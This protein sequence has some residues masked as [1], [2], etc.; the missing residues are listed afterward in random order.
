MKDKKV[1]LQDIARA[2]GVSGAT[3]SRVVNRTGRVSPEIAAR[4]ARIA[5]RMKVDLGARSRPRLIA[6]ILG[7]RPLLHP[8][9]SRILAGVEA[10]CASRDYHVVFVALRYAHDVPAEQLDLPRLLL[11]QDILDGFVLAGMHSGNLIDRL[12]RSGAPLAVHG[13]NVLPPWDETQHDAVWYDDV[14]GAHAMTRHMLALGHTD[15]WFVGN[16]RFPWFD[17]CHEGYAHAMAE[18]GLTARAIAPTGRQP[19]QAGYS[20]TRALLRQRAPVT[21]IVAGSDATAQG[22]VDALRE[23]GLRVPRDVSVGGLDD[24]EAAGMHPRLATV[25]VPLEDVGARLAEC[26]VSRIQAPREP[27]QVMVPTTLVAGASCAAVR[28]RRTPP[29]PRRVQAR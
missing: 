13:N 23:A 17:R 5:G 29:R 9:H 24:I 18:A 19:R 1:R 26:V 28:G 22:V 8:F 11:R 27:R 21:A 14:G 12:A 10:W 3:V 2:A 4:V 25:H 15:V 7:N 16:R 20:G 6:F